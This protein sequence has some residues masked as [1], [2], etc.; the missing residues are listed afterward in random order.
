MNGL[1][2]CNRGVTESN[3]DGRNL[4]GWGNDTKFV[5]RREITTRILALPSPTTSLHFQNHIMVSQITKH[6][7]ALGFALA[8]ASTAAIA[9]EASFQ[10]LFDGNSLDG[11]KHGGNWVVED[12]VIT[13]TGKG[14]SLV[15]AAA[16]IPDDFELR[17]E[18]KVAE[19]SNS[20]VYYRPGQYEYQIL[21]NAKHRDGTNPRTSAASLYFCMQPSEDKTRPIGQ[22]NEGRVVCKGTVVQHWLN[23]TKVID[24]DYADPKWAFNFKMLKQRGGDLNARGA[25]LSLQ[26][27]GDPVWYRNI[28]IRSI[29]AGEDIGHSDVTPEPIAPEVLKAEAEKLAGIVARRE[30]ARKKTQDKKSRQTKASA[31]QG[32]EQKPGKKAGDQSN[33][34]RPNVLF[35]LADDQSPFDLKVYDATSKLE[36]PNLDRIAA[37]GIVL[38]AA[39]HM[40]SWSGAVCTP[41][42]HMIMSGRSVWHIPNRGKGNGNP[43]VSDP[44]LVPP[45]LANYTM[46]PVFNRAGYDT[47]RTCKRGNS[48]DAANKL[49]TVVHEATKRG[50][51]H[52][53]GS[54]WHADRVLDYLNQ[55]DSS[56]D[57]DP[58]LIYF[59]FSHPHDTR[60]GTSELNAKYGAVN[61]K[62]KTTFPPANPNQPQLPI[63][64]LPEH[65]FHH[66]HP[67]LRDEVKVS[68][69]WERRD[70]RTIRN[71]LGREFACGENIDIQ[72]GRVL[73]KLE[74]MGELDNTYI[75][76]TADHGM[77]IGRHG[78]Q[79]KQNLYEHTW[80]VPFIAKGPG[81]PKGIRAPGNIYLM[82]V[83]ATVCE[84]TGVD[85][86]KTSEGISFAPVL[87]GKKPIVRD[88]LFGVYCGGTKPGMRCVKKGDWKLIKY[89]VLDGEVR[90][91]QLFNLASNP[92]EFLDQHHDASVTAMVGT[93]PEAT[94]VNL[95]GDP[96]YKKQLAEMEQLLL[97]E[98]R[99]LNDPYR[100]WNQ[101]QNEQTVKV[102]QPKAKKQK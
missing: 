76:Y 30:A 33:R 43:N 48:Y 52:E 28:R 16:K 82:D 59:G 94:Q 63:N 47:M 50:G 71:E 4:A 75:F 73:D 25:N 91:T 36:T 85:T 37:E 86:P 67:G 14:G 61:H 8:F 9:Q 17:F 54:A 44:S 5:Q 80:R 66:G 70:E 97:E 11:W 69:V 101:P 56:K 41:S 26:D 46:A 29:S 65:P 15:Y 22:W 21:D 58:F 81:I 45:E 49:F 74:A 23:G 93:D 87:F 2:K 38:D 83:L 78:L 99:R 79:G 12:G 7:V 27:H 100:L 40:G 72:I 64:Y 84:L 32:V 24:F 19:G 42:R 98:M 6:L 31:N 35:I 89:D 88:T 53:T 62:D 39:H 20:G 95:A 102:R 92:N 55:R 57:Q 77:A 68:G 3:P 18:W 51:T 34:K 90:E 10:T 1:L 13:R 60:D 96:N